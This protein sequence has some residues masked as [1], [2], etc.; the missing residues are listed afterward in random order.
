MTE[1]DRERER[2]EKRESTRINER[3]EMGLS[4]F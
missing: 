4:K 1:R 3:Y 2:Q